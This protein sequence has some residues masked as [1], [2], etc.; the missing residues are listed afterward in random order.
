VLEIG[1][2]VELTEEFREIGRFQSQHE[3][4]VAVITGAPIPFAEGAGHRQ[5]SDLFSVAKDLRYPDL[6]T[7]VADGARITHEGRFDGAVALI[8][9][10]NGQWS[11]ALT[12]I[13]HFTPPEAPDDAALLAGLRFVRGSEQIRDVDY[14]AYL[15]EMP[16]IDFTQ[17]HADLG[18]L[19]PLAAA[20][21]FVRKAQPLL[22]TD[23]G[24]TVQGIR[25]FFWKRASFTR[26][27]LRLPQERHVC[28]TALLRT[29]TSDP[30]A[31]ARMLA[32]NR[33]LY[34]VN[35]S[36]GGTLYP[37]AAVELT[38][39]DWRRHY[40]AQWHDLAKAKRRYDPGAVFASGPELYF[41]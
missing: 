33:T 25:M 17:S 6:Q 24:V 34:D 36:V 27:L 5:L 16:P 41:T 28:Y 3:G 15:D 2:R 8:M 14:F 1:V 29:P 30:E 35:R 22:T 21:A 4:L 10:M 23:A 18:L 32:V 40:G 26:P 11:Y 9:S 12:P 38:Q 39:E 19:M 13:R 20:P 37:F 31:V 7:L